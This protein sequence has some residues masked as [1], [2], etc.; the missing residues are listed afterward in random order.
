MKHFLLFIAAA[1]KDKLKRPSGR[2]ITVFVFVLMCFVSWIGMQFFSYPVP[3]W[4]FYSF[5]GVITAGMGFYT[6]EKPQP[7]KK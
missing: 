3:D 2:E 1:F 6:I 4:M 5:I 7:P